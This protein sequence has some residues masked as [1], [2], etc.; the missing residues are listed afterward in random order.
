MKKHLL[1]IAVTFLIASCG[2][3]SDIQLNVTTHSPE[4]D[5]VDQ[6]IDVEI[7]SSFSV[8]IIDPS[9][10]SDSLALYINTPSGTNLCTNITYDEES[11]VAVCSHDELEVGTQYWIKTTGLTNEDNVSIRELL[12]NFRTVAE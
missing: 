2:A 6:T 7:T 3:T 5:A 9:E 1:V 10:W 12:T 8:A 4:N 11:R